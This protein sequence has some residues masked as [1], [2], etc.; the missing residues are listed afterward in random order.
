MLDEALLTQVVGE[1]ALPYALAVARRRTLSTA[2]SACVVER[3][4]LVL[5]QVLLA[6]HGAA[7]DGTTIERILAEHGGDDRVL[8]QLARR[9]SLPDAVV[10]RFVT[11]LG[12]EL[13]WQ[14]IKSRSVKPQEAHRLPSARTA[15]VHRGYAA[16]SEAE[17][18]ALAE[19]ARLRVAGEL[20]PRAVLTLLR[21]RAIGRMEAALAV[22]AGIELRRTRLLLYDSDKRGLVALCLRAGFTTAEYVAFRMVLGLAELAADRRDRE[23]AYGADAMA[24]VKAQYE[25]ARGDTELWRRWLR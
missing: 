8:A 6:N 25:Q 5:L 18:R 12:A 16:G 23:V 4:D 21:D 2:L 1:L 11:D 15:H 17:Q 24:F 7:L 19:A 9:P 14:L 22:L 13:S 10:E 20:T 3:G